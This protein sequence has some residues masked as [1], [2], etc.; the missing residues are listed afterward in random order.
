MISPARSAWLAICPSPEISGKSGA[1][2][3]GSG[4]RLPGHS[5]DGRERLVEFMGNAGRHF[6]HRGEAGDAVHAL[7]GAVRFAFRAALIGVSRP[8]A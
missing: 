2:C 7:E 1:A 5:C 6:A 8:T 3:A 4:R